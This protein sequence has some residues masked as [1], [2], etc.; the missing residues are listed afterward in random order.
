M[1][2]HARASR[3]TVHLHCQNDHFALTVSDDGRGFVL[4]EVTPEHL[5]LTI[6]RERAED[7]GASLHIESSV[8][9]GTVI[10]VTWPGSSGNRFI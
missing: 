4:S 3:T 9:D 7:I 1:A 5:G 6:M 10:S 2:K 8:D